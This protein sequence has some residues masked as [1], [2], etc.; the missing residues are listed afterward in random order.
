MKDSEL[1]LAALLGEVTSASGYGLASIVRARGMERWAGLSPTSIYQGLRRLEAK[2]LATSAPD[3]E[4]SGRGPVGRIAGLTP[5]GSEQVRR[6]LTAALA[7]APEQSTRYR[8]ALAFAGLLE[9][10]VAVEQLRARADAVQVRVRQVRQVRQAQEGD[11][12]SRDSLGARLIFEYVLG[13]LEH[14]LVATGRLVEI[15]EKGHLP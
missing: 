12:E 4:K 8:I 14:E 2:G 15:L 13:A 11:L 5:L 1:A 9:A 10:P 7:E 6:E 3:S